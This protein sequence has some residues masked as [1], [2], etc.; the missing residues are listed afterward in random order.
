MNARA[1]WPVRAIAVAAVV[2]IIHVGVAPDLR[3]GG[4]AAE[5]PLALTIGAGLT[6]GTERGAIFGF[7]YGLIVDFF[8]F[9]PIGLSAL[10][11]GVLGWL[12][13][14]VF[15]DRFEESP[16]ASAVA[17]ALG[18]AAGLLAFVALGLILGEGALA[19]APVARIVL[20]ASMINGVAAV[21]LVEVCHWMWTID[22]LGR[23]T[24][25]RDSARRVT[26]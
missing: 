4:V 9:T 16:L 22:P 17:V 18:T 14:L 10:I 25:G 11:F 3:L 12:A 5:F 7:I 6:G 13:G 2:L 24:V 20:I 23:S 15:S 26:Q 8:L 19:E 1:T 21:V